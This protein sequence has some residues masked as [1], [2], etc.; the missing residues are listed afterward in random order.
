MVINFHCGP[1]LHPLSIIHSQ[2]MQIITPNASSISRS[3]QGGKCEFYLKLSGKTRR[4]LISNDA[5]GGRG[6]CGK[7]RLIFP[8]QI[9]GRT[10]TE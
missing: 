5:K 3:L 4:K 1:P 8:F 6:S 7:C 9:N 10:S 2:V